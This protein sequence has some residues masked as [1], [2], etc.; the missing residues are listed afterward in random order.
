MIEFDL[1]SETTDIL[2]WGKET[3]P[4]TAFML[5]SGLETKTRAE[6]VAPTLYEPEAGERKMEAASAAWMRSTKADKNKNSPALNFKYEYSVV[7]SFSIA[8]NR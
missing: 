3:T 1:E 8:K 5:V 7:L 4:E 2:S 6:N